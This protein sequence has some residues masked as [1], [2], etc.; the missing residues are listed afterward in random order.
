MQV[1]YREGVVN[2]SDPESCG[3]IREDAVEAL[4]GAVQ[5]SH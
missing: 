3:V 1:R 5:A 4:T 2:R